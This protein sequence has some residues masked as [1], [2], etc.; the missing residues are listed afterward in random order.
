MVPLL[1]LASTDKLGGSTFLL[2]SRMIEHVNKKKLSKRELYER[3]GFT[4]HGKAKP[5]KREPLHEILNDD[6]AK[7]D[8]LQMLL[9]DWDAEDEGA[10]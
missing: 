5:Y 8:H 2:G 3:D 10:M 7:A 6:Q 1:G 4:K 9:G